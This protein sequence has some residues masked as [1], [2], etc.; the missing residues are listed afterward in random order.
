MQ[1]KAPKGFMQGKIKVHAKGA[2]LKHAKTAKLDLAKNRIVLQSLRPLRL[3]SLSALREILLL[4][5]TL[6]L[7][8]VKL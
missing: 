8:C 7:H 5:K 3:F 1:C 4:Q 6:I 2:K